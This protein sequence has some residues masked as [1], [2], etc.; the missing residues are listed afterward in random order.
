MVDPLANGT[1]E[2]GGSVRTTPNLIYPLL[3]SLSLN[4]FMLAEAISAHEGMDYCSLMKV[5]SRRLE[6]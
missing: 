1:Q 3:W 6:D 5:I 4:I 2:S